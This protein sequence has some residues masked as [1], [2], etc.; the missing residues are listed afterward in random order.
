MMAGS[1][2]ALAEESRCRIEAIELWEYQGTREGVSGVDG[3][4]QVQ[5][6]HVYDAY[7]PKEYRETGPGTK[8]P[9]KTTAIYLKLKASG[10]LEGLYGPVDREA[11]IVIDQ[12]LRQ[13]LM[14]KDA[15]AGDVAWDQMWRLNRHGRAGIFM[16]AISAVDNALWD[17]RGRYFK[18][19]VYRLLGGPSRA[20]VEVYGSTLGSSVEPSRVAERA[21]ALQSQGFR[22]QKWFLADGP[23]RGSEGFA[24]NVKVAQILREALGPGAGLMFDVFNGWDLPYALRWCKEVE[25]LGLRWLEEPFSS[26]KVDAYARLSASTSVPIATGEHFYGRWE[27]QQFLKAD[28]IRVVQADPEWCGGVSELK[29]ICTLAS[30]YD[31]PV[32]P[33]GHNLHAA[34]HVVASESPSTCP[35][36]E[37]LIL[38][39]ASYYHFDANPMIPKDGTIALGESPGFGMEISTAKVE[40]AKLLSWKI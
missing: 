40:K 37:F 19:P 13:F 18:A 1:F 11:A 35:L 30:V 26:E 22:N 21:K 28:A 3:Q 39:M 38:K 29:K 12:Q 23:G 16:M 32:I 31:V 25:A 4:Y 9:Q 24:R 33:H 34:V 27:V 10:G 5:P 17:L 8:G 14:G 6:L 15:L 2:A 36:S 20:A 7:M